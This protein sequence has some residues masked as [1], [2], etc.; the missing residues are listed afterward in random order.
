MPEVT[1]DI[2]GRS[3][4]VACEAGEEAPLEQAAALLNSEA[5]TLQKAIGRVPEARMLLMSGLMLADRTTELAQKLG[6]AEAE[7][8]GLQAQLKQVGEN[9]AAVTAKALQATDSSAQRD[10]DAARAALERAAEAA[11][12]AVAVLTSTHA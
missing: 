8:A 1:L 12:A 9:A 3:F 10:A 4:R 11:E 7:I 2:G 5:E 6:S